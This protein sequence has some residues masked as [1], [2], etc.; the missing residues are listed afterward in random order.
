M[1]YQS[2]IPTTTRVNPLNRVVLALLTA[3]FLLALGVLSYLWS[4]TDTTF[5]GW[6]GFA[7]PPFCGIC[8]F[9]CGQLWNEYED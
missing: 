9:L 1:R 4:F 3:F 7:L 6:L 8:C 5:G 2:C